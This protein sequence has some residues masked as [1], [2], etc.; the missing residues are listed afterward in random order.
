MSAEKRTVSVPSAEI[1]ARMFGAFDANIKLVERAFSVVI[2]NRGTS[3]DGADM[4][5]VEG[6]NEMQIASAVKALEAMRR[7]AAEAESV[8]EQ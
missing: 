8:P 7:I 5:T 4:L 3:T 2:R 6:E 1:T